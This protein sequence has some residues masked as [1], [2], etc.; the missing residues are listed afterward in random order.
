MYT[1][2][3][4]HRTIPCILLAVCSCNNKSHVVTPVVKPLM[5]AV[6]ASGFV[7]SEDEHQ[8]FSEVDGTITAKL[9]DDGDIVT[10]D[11]PIFIIESGQQS[12]RF[13]I[14]KENYELALR[15]RS[16]NSPILHELN[17]AVDATQSKM[18][19]DSVNAV[20]YT[21]LWKEHATTRVEYDRYILQYK[22]SRNEY[23]AQSN[24]LKRTQ[25]QL[26]LELQNASNQLQIAGDE[27]GKYIV[28][29]RADGK[30]FKTVKE[31]GELVRRS[32]LLAVIGKDSGFY[33]QLSVDELDIQRIKEGQS[34]LVKID[35]FLDKIFHA[36]VRKIYPMVNRQQQSL[37]VDA[38]FEGKLP[39]SYS[40]LAV[41]AN[42]VI[43]QKEKAIVVPKTALLPGDSVIIKTDDG[44]KKIHVTTGIKTLDE[45]EITEGIKSDQLLVSFTDIHE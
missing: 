30:V 14:A 23:T 34:V 7:V 10:K 31:K 1:R 33:L 39:E 44:E 37:R 42:I 4:F 24:R 21:N 43:R 29:S 6:Y 5:E 20:R 15:N 27:S 11:A 28:T 26:R 12:A 8:L 35:A 32:E 17:A 19:F 13:R 45:V 3:V 41:E 25:D 18:E 2:P 9:A 40:G 22:N 16:D 36:T 38:S